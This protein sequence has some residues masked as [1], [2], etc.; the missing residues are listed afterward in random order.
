M[1]LDAIRLPSNDDPVA[2]VKIFDAGGQLVRIVPAH[3]FRGSSIADAPR[4]RSHASAPK[5]FRR[6]TNG[7]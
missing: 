3:E 2:P 5:P 7:S 4:A 6:L 1:S